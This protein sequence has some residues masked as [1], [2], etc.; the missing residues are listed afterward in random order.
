MKLTLVAALALA[1]VPV[2][3][4]ADPYR[5]SVRGNIET[6][7]VDVYMGDLNLSSPRDARE[8]SRRIDGAARYVCQPAPDSRDLA[9]RGDYRQCRYEAYDDAWHD[10]EEQ[11][12]GPIGQGR[13]IT[14][15]R[16]PGY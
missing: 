2:L 6:R 13:V 8:A 10:L 1:S 11:A 3:A 14:R 7:S 4:Q 9:E 12:G 15:E 5:V 16:V